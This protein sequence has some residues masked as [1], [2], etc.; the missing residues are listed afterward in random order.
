MKRTNTDKIVEKYFKDKMP[1][2]IRQL[3]AMTHYDLNFGPSHGYVDGID[4]ANDC[5]VQW[6]GFESACE[7]L[8]GWCNEMLPSEVW[9]DTDCDY[10]SVYEPQGEDIDGEYQEPFTE[11]TYHLTSKEIKRAVFGELGEYL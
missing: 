2:D 7:A 4:T 10:V 6:P 5:E 8:K 1:K 11:N 3:L 9:V